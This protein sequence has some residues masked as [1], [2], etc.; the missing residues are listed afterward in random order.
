MD[1]FVVCCLLKKKK[2]L[3]KPFWIF[4]FALDLF[5]LVFLRQRQVWGLSGLLEVWRVAWRLENGVWEMTNWMGIFK[6][7]SDILSSG[8]NRWKNFEEKKIFKNYSKK[9]LKY[10]LIE[11]NEKQKINQR[12]EDKSESMK[13][14]LC[15]LAGV[16]YW[17]CWYCCSYCCCC[18]CEYCCCCCEYCCCCCECCCCCCCCCC[19]CCSYSCSCLFVDMK[20]FSKYIHWIKASLTL[21]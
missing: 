6:N 3:K 7:S 9:P 15:G 20:W 5:S 21:E 17:R 4:L 13:Q 11:I 10:E 8:N 14:K 18:C 12:Q 16:L 19:W 2:T 1:I